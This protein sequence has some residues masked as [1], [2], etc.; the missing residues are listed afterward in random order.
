[1]LAG[2]LVFVFGKPML[3]GK[4]EPPNPESIKKPLIGPINLESLIYLLGLV[5]VFAVWGLLRWD[6]VV[7]DHMTNAIAALQAK[8]IDG[9]AHIPLLLSLE[10]FFAV[11]R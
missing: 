8:A 2:Y 1:M 3:E 7:R 5:G 10:N 4:G 6:A 11:R 9:V